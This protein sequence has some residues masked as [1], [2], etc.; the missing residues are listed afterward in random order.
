MTYVKM[1]EDERGDLVDIKHYCSAW[2]YVDGEGESAD[3]QLWPCPE[4]A[5]YPQYCPTCGVLTVPAI[6]GSE[7]NPDV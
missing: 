4:S 3:G 6:S 1:V 5:D 7:E 2:C